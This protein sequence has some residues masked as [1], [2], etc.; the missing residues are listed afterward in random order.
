MDEIHEIIEDYF[1]GGGEN[2]TQ[3]AYLID[4]HVREQRLKAGQHETIVM[5]PKDR[6]LNTWT[7]T[8]QLDDDT[9]EKYEARTATGDLKQAKETF[10]LL[11]EEGVAP[12][13]LIDLHTGKVLDHKG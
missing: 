4:K 12:M 9:F 7:N 2:I 5:L 13:W 3:L 8:R 6:Y 11:C 10:D 1:R